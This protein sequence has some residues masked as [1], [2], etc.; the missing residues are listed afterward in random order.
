M[1]LTDL[2]FLRGALADYDVLIY[3]YRS[4]ALCAHLERKIRSAAEALGLVFAAADL[5]DLLARWKNPDLFPTSLLCHVKSE[6]KAEQHN[7]R[8]LATCLSIKPGR[9]TA[10]FIPAGSDALSVINVENLPRTLLVEEHKVK[11]E[12]LHEYLKFLIAKTDLSVNPGLLN[13]RAFVSRFAARVSDGE[14]ASL[15]ELRREFNRAV[16]V[17]TDRKSG[18]YI[19]PTAFETSNRELSEIVRAVRSVAASNKNNGAG[20]LVHALSL[21]K[22]NGWSEAELFYE[23]C[24]ATGKILREEF[25]ELK[26]SEQN[27]V[28]LWAV[29][30]FSWRSRSRTNRP[31]KSPSNDAVIAADQLVREFQKRKTRK[32]DPLEGVW[33]RLQSLAKERLS[34]GAEDKITPAMKLMDVVKEFVVL[35]PADWSDRVRRALSP[36]EERTGA[37][38]SSEHNAISHPILPLSDVIGQDVAIAAIRRRFS[39]NDHTQPLVIS[40]PE[41]VGKRTFGRGYAKALL[42]E[43]DG[44]G[45]GGCQECSSCR[46]IEF[47]SLGYAEFD[48]D[49]LRKVDFTQGQPMGSEARRLAGSLQSRPFVKHRVILIKNAGIQTRDL[50]AFLKSFES[51]NRETTFV[52]LSSDV[53]SV[54]SAIVSRCL[55]MRLIRLSDAEARRLFARW[56]GATSVGAKLADLAVLY[57]NG[58]PGRLRRAFDVVMAQQEQS[59][60]SCKDLLGLGW[61]REAMAVWRAILSVGSALPVTTGAFPDAPVEE[62]FRRLK[63]VLMNMRFARTTNL[64]GNGVFL[65]LEA[66]LLALTHQLHSSDRSKS[67]HNPLLWADIATE[68]A[69][70]CYF[71]EEGLAELLSATRR[72]L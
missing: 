66:E 32:S 23:L 9:Q 56:A 45:L 40:G 33:G 67:T 7:V 27:D 4:G 60:E 1:I 50:D 2:E 10:I 44:G 3:R 55:D 46:T 21:K 65:G 35:G 41:G 62:R 59:V 68:W 38:A 14:I 58:L 49:Q 42:C 69:R 34:H 48:L 8:A 29:L 30:L 25:N 64:S 31:G 71:G 57:A 43:S 6:T 26:P 15:R 24:R 53:G 20:P 22:Q 19:P 61:G 47:G 17:D 5:P 39:S 18:K 51:R 11:A 52:L 54:R 13:D 28:L 37:V 12:N 16:L 36:P 72:L 63:V 70:D